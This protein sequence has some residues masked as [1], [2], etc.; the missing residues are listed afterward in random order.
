[1]TTTPDDLTALAAE[2]ATPTPSDALA[3][4][5]AKIARVRELEA[6]A[7][8]L[9]ERLETTQ[10]DLVTLKHKTL[11]DKMVEAGI[12]S[13]G[14]EAAGNLPAVEARLSN[15][16][17]ANIAADWDPARRAE[18]FAYLDSVG[19]RDI[20]GTTVTISF[21]RSKEERDLADRVLLGLRKLNVVY[22]TEHG[23]PWA[24][25][26]AWLREQVEHK[27]RVPDLVKIGG[28]VGQVVK[29]KQKD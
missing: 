1:M 23:V 3:A 12:T 10:A 27:K 28:T 9:K 2:D 5:R 18:G 29:L 13:L 24:T 11:P 8:D 19:A 17:H 22:R 7:A 4:I 25:L 14:I 16:Y 15:Y 20:V 21:G 6:L 26:T